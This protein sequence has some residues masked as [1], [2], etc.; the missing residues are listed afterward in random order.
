MEN[1]MIKTRIIKVKSIEN[2]ETK[3]AKIM[4]KIIMKKQQWQ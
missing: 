2:A 4:I 3:M 1:G